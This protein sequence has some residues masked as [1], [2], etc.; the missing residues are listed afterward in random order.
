MP[1][2]GISRRD[3]IPVMHGGTIVEIVPADDICF[4]LRQTYRQAL[5]VAVPE[6][7]PHQRTLLHAA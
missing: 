2:P 7:D 3:A 1:L 5:P 6:A 4:R